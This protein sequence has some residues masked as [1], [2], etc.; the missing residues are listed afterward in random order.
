MGSDG[1][2][3]GHGKGGRG[4]RGRGQGRGRSKGKSSGHHRR[5]STYMTVER[6]KAIQS[7]ADRTGQNAGFKGRAMSAATRHENNED[8]DEDE[9]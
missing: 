6:A 3:R 7:H 4:K 8:L 1:R 5:S 9:K 2:D